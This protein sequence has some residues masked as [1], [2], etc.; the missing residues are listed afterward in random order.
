MLESILLFLGGDVMT[1]RGIDQVLP[2]SSPPVLYEPYVKD[3]RDYVRLA[4]RERGALP[5]P[6]PYE[7]VWGDA[8]AALEKHRPDYRIVNLETALTTSDEPW[9][10]KSIH[11]HMHPKNIDVLAVADID[12][13]SLANN[14]V[15]DWGYPGLRQTLAVLHEAGIKTAGAGTNRR[16]ADAPAVLNAAD[17]RRLL[18]YAYG[19]PGS[20]VPSD[21]AAGKR[22]AGV[23]FLPRLSGGEADAVEH[24]RE[25]SGENDLVIVSLHWGDNWGYKVEPEQVSFAHRL[26]DKGGVDVVYGHSSHHPRPLE[27][28]HGKLI[29]YGCGDLINDYEGIGG[30]EE[31]RGDLSLMYLPRLDVDTGEL[32]ELTLIP[33]QILRFGLNRARADDVRWLLKTLNRINEPFGVRLREMS[34]DHALLWRPTG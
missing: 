1:G 26:I 13:A 31:Y 33:F 32:I 20:G 29:L 9:P 22:G 24:I 6:M 4:A 3:A 15:V 11:Y 28:H 17:D 2:H 25:T 10:G 27:I 23:N 34:G 21:W 30:H 8:L 5:R 19:L 16:A 14:H 18:I 12:V 7:L